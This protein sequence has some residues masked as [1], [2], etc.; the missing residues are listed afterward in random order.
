MNTVIPVRIAKMPI[1]T[2]KWNF[3]KQQIIQE[4]LKDRREISEI[5]KKNGKKKNKMAHRSKCKNINS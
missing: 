3:G 5:G 2:L 1:N 4:D